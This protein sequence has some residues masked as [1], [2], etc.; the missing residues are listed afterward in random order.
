[1]FVLLSA[2]AIG[3]FLQKTHS[4]QIPRDCPARCRLNLRVECD[5][6]AN[7]FLQP[8]VGIEIHLGRLHGLVPRP[9]RDDRATDVRMMPRRLRESESKGRGNG[10]KNQITRVSIGIIRKSAI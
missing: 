9:Q 4:H 1:M 5:S 3:V 2:E 8:Q 10:P 6:H 7:F